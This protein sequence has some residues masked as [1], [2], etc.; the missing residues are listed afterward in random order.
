MD[1][2]KGRHDKDSERKFLRSVK[3][4]TITDKIR[5]EDMEK[6]LQ[7]LSTDKKT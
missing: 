4:R 6:E 2:K 3:R 7:T 1:S 5:D